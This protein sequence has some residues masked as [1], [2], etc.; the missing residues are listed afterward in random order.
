MKTV[1]QTVN[2]GHKDGTSVCPCILLIH[3]QRPHFIRNILYV[4]VVISGPM[5]VFM[6]KCV[7]E[8]WSVVE[9]LCWLANTKTFIFSL[10]TLY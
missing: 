5:G 2:K 6:L 7:V 8:K 3:T 9:F 1:T 10:F 4:P